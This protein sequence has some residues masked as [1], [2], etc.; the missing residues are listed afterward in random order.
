[1]ALLASCGGPSQK[2]VSQQ[3]APGS[4]IVPCSRVILGLR[5][6][7]PYYPVTATWAKPAGPGL[8]R[9]QHALAEKFDNVSNLDVPV[10]LARAEVNFE[11][12][13]LENANPTPQFP[14][15]QDDDVITALA[16][17]CGIHQI[18]GGWSS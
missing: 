7:L 8:Y 11:I 14:L 5:Q 4:A 2:A 9:S 13:V 6:I 17:T 16:E 18:Y 10:R 3:V 12:A 15:V 1:M